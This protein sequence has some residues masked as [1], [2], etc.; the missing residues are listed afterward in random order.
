MSFLLNVSPFYYVAIVCLVALAAFFS[1]AEMAFASANRIRLENA[2]EN[3]DK[4]AKVACAIFD[5]YEDMLSTVLICNNLVNIAASS[6][7]SVIALLLVGDGNSGLATT[8]AS[9]TITLLIIVFSETIPKIVAK[10]NANR[11]STSFAYIIRGLMFILKPILFVIVGAISL[12]T[13]PFKGERPVDEQ[14]A[15]ALE[16]VS[17]IET[18]EGEGVI[19]EERSE[20]LQAA[21]D[22]SDISA[23]E[24]MTSRVDMLSIDIDDDWDEIMDT[25]LSSSYSRL[26]VYEDSIDNI[27]GVLYL[28]HFFKAISGAEQIDIRPLLLT[29][30]FVYKTLKLPAVLA[31]MRKSRTHIA[32]VT[33]EYGGSM[34]L[35]TMEDVFEELVGEIW[36]ETDAV[37]EEVIERA[38]NLYELDGDMNMGDFLEMLDWDENAIETESATVGGWTIESLEH[39]PV[40][41]EKMSYENLTLIVLEV[42]GQRVE[43]VLV[44]VGDPK[45]K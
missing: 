7:A 9:V 27:I 41:G 35:V 20:L 15:A 1:A 26:P 25:I 17:I 34:G 16:L 24:I 10:K 14:E 18:V 44:K 3:G 32:I 28:N 11:Y 4:S 19:D 39:F 8:I 30:C 40:R 38:E 36:D 33:D 31:E 21:L 42:S 29:P 23:S 37:E 22:F 2:A 12:I 45:T 43:R 13:K 6:I 5:R